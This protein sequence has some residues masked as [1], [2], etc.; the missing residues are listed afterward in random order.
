MPAK[1]PHAA[2]V[3]ND[4]DVDI[5]IAKRGAANKLFLNNGAGYFTE[6]AAI[7]GL[8]LNH[9]SR[10]AVWADLDN[11]GDLDLL[12]SVSSTISDPNPLLRAFKNN[13]SGLFQDV[14]STLNIPMNGFSPL[15][16]DFDLDG[17]LDIITTS[18]NSRG[19]FYRNNGSW[20][21]TLMSSTGAEVYA[22]DTRSGAVFDYDNDGDL[23]FY[24]TRS[25]IF[26]VLKENTIANGS[27][28]LL[29]STI[30]PGNSASA[31]GTKIWCYQAGGAGDPAALLGYREVL[32]GSGHL[33]QY[34]LTQHFGL[35]SRASCDLVVQFTDNTFVLMRQVAADQTITV[36]PQAPAQ[37]A[38]APA[39][40]LVYA[41][42][43][44]S[45]PVGSQLPLPLTARVVDSN[46]LPVAGV[47]VDFNVTQGDATVLLPAGAAS[48]ALWLEAES[49][50]P[51]GSLAWA[52]DAA[53]SGSGLVFVPPQGRGNGRDSLN[54][55]IPASAA[56]SLWLRARTGSSGAAIGATMD[57]GSQNAQT[58]N[59]GSA[60]QWQRLGSPAGWALSAGPHRLVLELSPGALQ[61]DRL[62]L[63]TDPAYVPSGLGESSD[64]DP[65]ASDSQG[66]AQRRVQLG[67]QAGPLL[68]M[69]SVTAD[70]NSHTAQ[71]QATAR[72]GPAATIDIASG[73]NQSTTLPGTPLPFPIC[74]HPARCLW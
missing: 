70:G 52:Y 60:W 62:L 19:A 73:N 6:A 55:T 7:A 68:V 49:G 61:I 44:Q 11:D 53:S 38:G 15:T 2:D 9:N 69:A 31:F 29:V 41:G 24:L 42:Q 47:H 45:A 28:Y 12:V 57:S 58:I 51:G 14:S 71:F 37:P 5:Y 17:D 46:G 34:P 21:F 64:S 4:G 59:T 25:D 67:A 50:R 22:G 1:P 66:M 72:P 39:Q 23:D 18:E 13:G 27:H 56:W 33:A 20:Q 65:F 3:D 43:S 10:S 8:A 63:S 36:S 26:N 16:G 35:G 40:L 74:R 32:S 54:F 30:G 48:S